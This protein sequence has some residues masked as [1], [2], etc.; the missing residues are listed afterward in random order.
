MEFLNATFLMC[1]FLINAYFIQFSKVESLCQPYHAKIQCCG[2]K[3]IYFRLWLRLNFSPYLGSGFSL[4][5][6]L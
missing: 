6:K 5:L 3:I 1:Q 4:K 2:A